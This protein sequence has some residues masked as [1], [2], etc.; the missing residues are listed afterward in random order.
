[1]RF[2][3]HNLTLIECKCNHSL[4]LPIL[5]HRG[6]GCAVRFAAVNQGK[7]AKATLIL[8]AYVFMS[9]FYC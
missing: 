7:A 3:I 8:G 1:M 4:S 2:T 5:L 9:N 6:S